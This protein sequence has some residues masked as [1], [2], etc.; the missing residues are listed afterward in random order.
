M[1][2]CENGFASVGVDCPTQGATKCAFQNSEDLLLAVNNCLAF[3]VPTGVSY[4]DCCSG[5]ADC[6]AAGYAYEM[7]DWDVSRVTSMARLFFNKTQFNRDISSWNTESVTDMSYMFYKALSFNGDI[8]SWNT[9]SVTNMEA[10]FAWASA[11]NQNISDWNTESVGNMRWMFDTASSFDQDLSGWDVSQVSRNSNMWGGSAMESI[12][13]NK[14]C[15]DDGVFGH[16]TWPACE[17]V[18]S[19]FDP[20]ACGFSDGV[21]SNCFDCMITHCQ[22]EYEFA[23]QEWVDYERFVQGDEKDLLIYDICGA[24]NLRTCMLGSEPAAAP[25]VCTGSGACFCQ[26][27][28][29]TFGWESSTMPECPAN[30]LPPGV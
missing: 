16:V 17:F 7:P 10:M 1:C 9:G 15:T 11:F 23:R 18:P 6:G 5:G 19:E 14:P 4:L 29:S 27:L 25:A 12:D 21:D 3:G 2:T 22:S 13:S 26:G 20:F 8:S 28:L 24:S 30:F